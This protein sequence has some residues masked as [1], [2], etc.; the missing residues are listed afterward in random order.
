MQTRDK[1]ITKADV[2]RIGEAITNL[3]KLTDKTKKYP[4]TLEYL[5]NCKNKL[6]VMKVFYAAN[7]GY[8]EK[9]TKF[10][11]TSR[12]LEAVFSEAKMIYTYARKP[13]AKS[14]PADSLWETPFKV[15]DL[16]ILRA[17]WLEGRD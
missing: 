6:G 1:R 12:E 11:Y 2:N 5:E 3:E 7:L 15:F 17:R 4:S 14:D 10:P 13:K 9:A 8:M 16:L